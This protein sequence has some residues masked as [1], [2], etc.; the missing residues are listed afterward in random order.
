MRRRLSGVLAFMILLAVVVATAWEQQ[1]HGYRDASTPTGM[2]SAERALDTVEMIASRPHPVGS[3]E[4]DQV[5]EQLAGQLRNLGLD[6]E[7]RYGVGRYPAQ[8]ERDVLGMARVG[9]IVARRPGRDSTGTVYLMA[10]YD[11]VPS[12][13]GANDDG[14]GVA[15]IVEAVR[16]LQAS[17]TTLRNDLVVVLTDAEEL[18]LLGAEA[19]VASG[20]VDPR[21]GVVINHEARGAGGPPLMWRTSRPNSTLISA[22]GAAPH[23]NTDS[24]STRLAG[25]QTSSNTDFAALDPVGL[26][27]LDWAFAGQNAYYHN[28]FDDPG[29]VSLA[30]VQQFGDNTVALAR[31]F[32]ERDLG[33]FAEENS[34]YFPLPFGVLVVLPL[35]VIVVLAVATVLIVGWVMWRMRRS[36]EASIVRSLGSAATAVF[37]IP[38]A[39]AAVYGLWEAIITIRP[40]YRVLFV[41]PYRPEFYY[42]AVLVLCLAVL[43]AWYAL[44]RRWFGASATVAGLLCGVAVIGAVSTAIEPAAAVVV[45]IPVFTAALGVSLTFVVPDPWRLPVLTILLVPSAVVLGTWAFAGLQGGIAGAPYLTA[46]AVMVLGVLLMPTLTHAWPSRRTAIIPSA[47]LVLTVALAAAGL[48]VDRFD[49]RHPLMSQLSYALDADHHEAQWVSQQQPDHWTR[50]FVEPS[51]PRAQFA[52][53]WSKAVASGSAP[54]GAL[55]APSAEILSDTTDSGRRTVG[56]RLRSTRGADSIALRYDSPPQA[57]RVS[58]RD[59]TPVPRQGFQ[60]SAVPTEGIEVQLTAPAGPLELQVIDYSWLP[61][62]HL[63]DPPADIFYRQDSTV[64]VFTTVTA[65]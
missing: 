7:I 43:T 47:A 34:A 46:P 13:P 10:H 21:G 1:P 14:V 57:L 25:A 41:D 28:P 35:W 12:G 32:G 64:A 8:L 26:R 30:T 3:A 33:T 40:Q 60:F 49:D 39:M 44:S 11:S 5:R 22:V 6:T 38:V 48:A 18:G 2:F 45:V 29:H 53:L 9:N 42:A 36:G 50:R 62:S 24:L 27:V 55:S 4:H 63:A 52:G 20:G 31:D 61:D 65:L 23:P 15:T 59:I 17:A 16:A 37:S 51:P 58:G 19:F 54:I 56:L